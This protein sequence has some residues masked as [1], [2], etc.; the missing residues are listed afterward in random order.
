M[1]YEQPALTASSSNSILIAVPSRDD[2]KIEVYQFPDEKLVSF[3]PRVQTTDTGMVMAVKL[4]HHQSSNSILVIAGYEGGFTAVHLLDLSSRDTGKSIPEFAKLIYLSQP[5]TQP[6][7]SLDATPDAAMYFTSSADAVIAAHRVPDILA[8]IHHG[9]EPE[10]IWR[11]KN[12][13]QIHPA[14][15]ASTRIAED[16]TV[17]EEAEFMALL[18]A[19]NTSSSFP[20]TS[21]PSSSLASTSP[22]LLTID[23]PLSFTKQPIS[24]NPNPPAGLS[25]LLSTASTTSS[26]FTNFQPIPPPSPFSTTVQPPY[27]IASTKH[28]GQQSL[29]VRSDGR[30]FATGGWDSRIRVYSAKTL[31]EVACLKWHKE[32]V[33]AVGFGDILDDEDGVQQREDKHTTGLSA[34]GGEV[35]INAEVPKSAVDNGLSKFQKQREEQIRKKHW[36]VAGSKDGKVSL[37][38]VF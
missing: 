34:L 22:P 37:W 3:V 2:K 17:A 8:H 23:T 6:V 16:L 36:L 38:E 26:P 20:S 5:H 33:Y 4:A 29:S 1:C 14:T 7:L 11:Q 12:D 24:S 31:K 15:E 19:E 10:S 21:P 28:A 35:A 32:G 25:S 13:A 18:S 30:L 27:K 9:D